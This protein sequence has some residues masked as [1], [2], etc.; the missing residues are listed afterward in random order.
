MS[1]ATRDYALRRSR[2]VC[3]SDSVSFGVALVRTMH[4]PH[5]TSK[6]ERGVLSGCRGLERLAGWR[7]QISRAQASTLA[8]RRRS[9][10]RRRR[11]A[12]SAA[13]R[14]RTPSPISLFEDDLAGFDR[15]SLRGR[16]TLHSVHRELGSRLTPHAGSGEVFACSRKAGSSSIARRVNVVEPISYPR[17]ASPSTS[18]IAN[19]GLCLG[20]SVVVD[21]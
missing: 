3:V 1:D 4:R 19:E 21:W 9:R 17:A 18:I 13:P 12:R 8:L 6:R 16:R 15:A 10:A 14:A 5:A 20:M 7:R 11:V 2:S